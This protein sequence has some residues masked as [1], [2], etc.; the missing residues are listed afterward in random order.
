MISIDFIFMNVKGN[1][2]YF[3][4]SQTLLLLSDTSSKFDDYYKLLREMKISYI[5]GRLELTEHYYNMVEYFC[6]N[7]GIKKVIIYSISPK[8]VK[9]SDKSVYIHTGSSNFERDIIDKIIIKCKGVYETSEKIPHIPR[10]TELIEA[11]DRRNTKH[12]KILA[13]IG[14]FYSVGSFI[15]LVD[16]INKC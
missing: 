11:L 13:S 2:Y 1:A 5:T 7:K 4:D 10:I 8:Y 15:K 16:F 12:P 6:K 3:G 9:N 14:G